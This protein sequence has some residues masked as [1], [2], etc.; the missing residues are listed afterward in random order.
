MVKV[1]KAIK[2]L[3]EISLP[4]KKA[5]CI[6]RNCWFLFSFNL[7]YQSSQPEFAC[8]QDKLPGILIL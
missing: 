5:L 8:E 2:V 4:V 6:N 7:D 3:S 1:S